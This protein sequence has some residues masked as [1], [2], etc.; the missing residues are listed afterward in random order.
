MIITSIYVTDAGSAVCSVSF[1][2]YIATP[3]KLWQSSPNDQDVLS[4]SISHDWRTEVYVVNPGKNPANPSESLSA[5]FLK[6]RGQYVKT[7]TSF[8]ANEGIAVFSLLN[9]RNGF[10]PGTFTG[11]RKLEKEMEM[12]ARVQP[13][14]LMAFLQA[15]IEVE[16]RIGGVNPML[17]AIMDDGSSD[18]EGMPVAQWGNG[19]LNSAYNSNRF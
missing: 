16:K 13:P 8:R 15:I 17:G 3:L 2:N 14:S 5:S 9:K 1:R 7:S 12:S 6:K 18:G 11:W 19:D 4:A 10:F